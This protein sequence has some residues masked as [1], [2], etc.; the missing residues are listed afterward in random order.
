M[1]SSE[2]AFVRK[3][4]ADLDSM[5][6]TA[7]LTCAAHC[8][9]MPMVVTLLPLVGLGFLANEKIEWLL[10]ASSATLGLTSL[11]LGFRKHKR[12]R[13]LAILAIG[14]AFLALGR[15]SEERHLGG[16]SVIVVVLGGSI[17][18]ASHLINRK[19]CLACRHCQCEAN[20]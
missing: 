8:A 7:S 19:L 18:A 13:T 20:A 9:L 16:W 4:H 5:G 10:V 2:F 17:V 14:L 11:C 3:R 6:A 1:H 15:I 12:R